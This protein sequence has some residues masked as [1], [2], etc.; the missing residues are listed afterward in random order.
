M[1]EPVNSNDSQNL[2]QFKFSVVGSRY[3]GGVGAHTGC[4]ALASSK[5]VDAAQDTA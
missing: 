4:C 3:D 2:G 1:G 5:S